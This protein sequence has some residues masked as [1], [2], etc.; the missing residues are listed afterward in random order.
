LQV[1]D[2][3]AQAVAWG[4]A[5]LPRQKKSNSADLQRGRTTITGFICTVAKKLLQRCTFGEFESLA[6]A[7][8]RR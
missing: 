6:L 8:R 2:R 4:V 1:L 3:G 5:M 7:S